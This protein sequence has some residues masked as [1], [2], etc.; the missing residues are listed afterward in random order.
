M[1]QSRQEAEYLMEQQHYLPDYQEEF[2]EE[3]T[4]VRCY[5]MLINE[6]TL[7]DACIKELRELEQESE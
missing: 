6:E 2:D 5:S 4:C 3:D 1:P 7:C